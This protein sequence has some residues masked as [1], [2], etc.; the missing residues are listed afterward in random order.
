MI[1]KIHCSFYIK[2]NS[3]DIILSYVFL[4]IRFHKKNENKAPHEF[5][6]S[7]NLLFK[8]YRNESELFQNDFKK[9]QELYFKKTNPRN[10]YCD[11]LHIKQKLFPYANFVQQARNYMESLGDPINN[12]GENLDP[13]AEQQNEDPN[14]FNGSSF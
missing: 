4:K 8:H 10:E 7:E 13:E 9:C 3:L 2:I 12:I 14:I 5:Y 1:K 6:Y 11:V